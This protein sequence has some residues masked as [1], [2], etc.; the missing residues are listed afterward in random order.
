MHGTV[1]FLGLYNY[2]NSIFDDLQVPAGVDKTLV[3]NT[4]MMETADLEVL[5]PD[6]V[7]MRQVLGWFSQRRLDAWT[8]VYTALSSKYQA[9]TDVDVT[10][11]RTP[12]LSYK[13]TRTP[14]L[15]YKE[16]RTPDLTTTGQNTGAD[17]TT[18]KRAGFNAG[19]L[20][21][22]EQMETSLGTGN[23]IHSTGNETTDRTETGNETTDRTETGSETKTTT[24]RH[25]A[26]QDLISKEMQLAMTDTVEYIVK[27]IRR[28][29]CLLV[30]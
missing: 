20:E 21:T 8:R 13:E 29:F 4:L 23:T 12:D 7:I 25:Q 11:T 24:G 5:Q 19:N 17:T 14:D 28:N 22:A 2:D 27:D 1:S 9:D 18:T 26:A 3:Q 16:T 15:S 30:Y 10:E 6:P